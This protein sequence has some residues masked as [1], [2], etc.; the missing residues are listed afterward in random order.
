[1]LLKCRGSL[2]CLKNGRNWTSVSTW[3]KQ[4]CSC[5]FSDYYRH[6]VKCDCDIIDNIVFSNCRVYSEFK[7]VA[8][9]LS[10][11]VLRGLPKLRTQDGQNSEA[12]RVLSHWSELRSDRAAHCRKVVCSSKHCPKIND[13]WKYEDSVYSVNNSELTLKRQHRCRSK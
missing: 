9:V 1:M 6:L 13:K 2:R 4:L 11:N 3:A 8:L 7:T 10:Y 12:G 5:W